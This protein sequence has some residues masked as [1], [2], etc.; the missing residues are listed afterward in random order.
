[1][2]E[3][4]AACS[5]DE[6]MP[7]HPLDGDGLHAVHRLHDSERTIYLGRNAF[8]TGP[9]RRPS[10][11]RSPDSQT[12]TLIGRLLADHIIP[13]QPTQRQRPVQRCAA[14]WT[15]GS[16]AIG[17]G[18]EVAASGR[19]CG[20]LLRAA[21]EQSTQS[22]MRAMRPAPDRW[23]YRCEDT[24][25]SRR[26]GGRRVMN[27]QESHDANPGPGDAVRILHRRSRATRV[28]AGDRRAG[29]F[30]SH[31]CGAFARTSNRTFG[32]SQGAYESV[33]GGVR[34]SC[35]RIMVTPVVHS[36]SACQRAASPPPR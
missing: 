17:E 3:V 11:T 14:R 19:L 29:R 13:T 1:M 24:L 27:P 20:S 7:R 10:S 34:T 22:A 2:T 32:L 33:G 21:T 31:R 28:R 18:C 6:A 26:I 5:M 30:G 12:H 35:V 16:G 25:Q 15:A 4:G 36:C 23:A 9:A 8:N